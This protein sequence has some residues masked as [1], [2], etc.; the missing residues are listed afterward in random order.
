M[1]SEV[2]RVKVCSSYGTQMRAVVMHEMQQAEALAQ[3]YIAAPDAPLQLKSLHLALQ[4]GRSQV[5][6][7]KSAA[8]TAVVIADARRTAV[9]EERVAKACACGGNSRV[10]QRSQRRI[11]P[12]TRYPLATGWV[13]VTSQSCET[14]GSW[15]CVGL[16]GE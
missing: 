3:D 14:T 7:S 10:Q 9:P 6:T 1:S 16:V 13:L 4:A 8:V 5:H 12:G 11:L 15:S 2:F